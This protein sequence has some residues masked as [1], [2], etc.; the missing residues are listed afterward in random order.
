V[1]RVRIDL[2]DP[3]STE[4]FAIGG[5][6]LPLAADFTAPVTQALGLE[7][8][9]AARPYGIRDIAR[10]GTCEGFSALTPGGPDRVPLILVEGAGHSPLMMAQL[11]NEIAG[12]VD[13]RRRY[14]VWLY[15]FS[16]VAPLFFAA[17]QLRRDLARFQAR[18]RADASAPYDGRGIAVAHGPGALLARSLIVAPG[19]RVW[20]AVFATPIEQMDLSAYDRTLLRRLF[21]W[22]RSPVVDRVIVAREPR[23]LAALTAGVGARAPQLLLRQPPEFRQSVERIYGTQKRHLRPMSHLEPD[24]ESDV[25]GEPICRAIAAAV[26]GADHALATLVASGRVDADAA[27]YRSPDGSGPT[28]MSVAAQDDAPLGPLIARGILD[29]LRDDA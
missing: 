27:L 2:L 29:W 26:H 8:R 12:A 11:A 15:R 1:R 18:L 5:G 16:T 28:T 14:Q 3:V 24:G 13:L 10:L 7:R 21:F 9:P 20:D 17:A 4:T 23:D 25:G 6:V 19:A 22:D